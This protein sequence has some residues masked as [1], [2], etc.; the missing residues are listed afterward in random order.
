VN[1]QDEAGWLGVGRLAD[2]VVLD[3]DIDATGAGPIGD[4]R[5]V[6]TMIGGELVFE[7]PALEG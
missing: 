3:R 2:L 1:R 5:V 4:T 7:A 6:A